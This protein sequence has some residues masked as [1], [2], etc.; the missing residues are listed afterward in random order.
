[1]RLKN[2]TQSG[3]H[4][5]LL[6][7]CTYLL[8]LANIVL[9]EVSITHIEPSSGIPGTRITIF[10][11]GF[12]DTTSNNE[13]LIG[14]TI[15]TV[16]SVKT[17]RLFV[18]VPD[19]SAGPTS[20][21][22]TV[23]STQN[24]SSFGFTIISEPLGQ[25][26]FSSQKVIST[27]GDATVS[28]YSAD[29]DGDGDLDVL[30]ASVG[31]DK[32][33]WYENTDGTGTFGPQQVISIFTNTPWSVYSADLDGDGDMDVLSASYDDNKIAWY[34]N[35]DG[36][37]TFGPQQVITTAAHGALSVYSAD[38]D[39]D[40]DM[41]V[42]SS[43]D[44]INIAWYENTDGAGA[45]GI[46]QVITTLADYA[47]CVYS[48]DLDGDGDMDVL[49]AS[50]GDD[51]IA[52]YE[53]SDG[54][55]TF[56]AQQV[57]TILADR[58]SSVY[59]ADIDGDGNLDVLSAS[60]YNGG[61]KI[62]WYKNID[63]AGTF[64]TQHLITTEAVGAYSVYSGDLD[65]DGDMDVLSASLFDDK[66]AWY[67]NTDGAG[68]FGAQQVIT[69]LADFAY[70]VYSADIDGDGDLDVLS[71]SSYDDK[72]AWYEN[73]TPNV[74]DPISEPQSLH[75][76]IRAGVP[77]LS[78]SPNTEP[79]LAKYYIY[80]DTESQAGAL[81]DSISI[82]D[83]SY[84]DRSAALNQQNFYRIKAVSSIGM[85][86]DYS[87][88][89]S[90]IPPLS[91][92]SIQPNSGIA[93]LPIIL[94]GVGFSENII[95]N[96]LRFG[97]VIAPIDSIKDSRIFTT[98]PIREPGVVNVV[99]EV[100]G[101]LAVW[102]E[103][104]TV[105]PVNRD[106]VIVG[107]QQVID[108]LEYP[109]SVHSA[110]LDGDGDMDIL[111][112]SKDDDKILWFENTDGTGTFGP[113]QEIISSVDGPQCVYS[114]DLDN[115]GDADVIVASV[116]DDKV[117]WY[118]NTDGEGAFGP[119][120]VI[121]NIADGAFSV[122]SADIDGDGDMDVLSASVYDDK[123]AW[124]ENTDGVGGFGS[125]Q[126]I[127]TLAD[128][129]Y[130]V[131][132]GDLD[133][134]G[135][136]DVLSASRENDRIAWYENTDGQ[137]TFG[138]QQVISN[139]AD[140]ARSVFSLDLDGDGDLD[141]LSGS[142]Y[143][144]KI[145]W[146]ENIDGVGTFGPEQVITT[147]LDQ[148]YSI[149]PI[150]FDGDG[151]MDVLSTAN[152][153]DKILWYENTD[154]SGTFGPPQEIT[155]STDGPQAIY[156]ADLDNDGDMDVLST[157]YNDN[158]LAWYENMTPP[159]YPPLAPIN[160]SVSHGD[161]SAE[162]S[163]TLS[164][165]ENQDSLFLY[166]G[167][168]T[169]PNNLIMQLSVS[170]DTFYTD[171]GLQNGLTYYYAVSVVDSLGQESP[172]STVISTIPNRAPVMSMATNLTWNEDNSFQIALDTVLNDD[173]D[174][175]EDIELSIMSN[176][177]SFNLIRDTFTQIIT[178]TPN[179]NY[180]GTEMLII[181]AS[182][183][184][185]DIVIDSTEITI[186][187]VN[188]AP[189]ISSDT[190]V[191]GLEEEWFVYTSPVFDVENDPINFNYVD[192]PDWLEADA[193][194][195]FGIPDGINIDTTVALIV[196]DSALQDTQKVHISI[197]YINDT[198]IQTEPFEPVSISAPTDWNLVLE[199]LQLNFLDEEDGQNLQ[200]SAWSLHPDLDSLRLE[201]T[202]SD[203]NLELHLTD[204]LFRGYGDIMLQ[205]SDAQGE[206]VTDTFRVM[207][208]YD[209]GQPI[210]ILF[211][212]TSIFED[213]SL[214]ILI[215]AVDF[216]DDELLFSASSSAPEVGT[217]IQG[218]ELVISPDDDWWGNSHVTVQVSDGNQIDS[219]TFSLTILP[220]NDAPVIFSIPDT[221]FDEDDITSIRLTY[222]D[223]DD[224]GL[225][226]AAASNTTNLT[227]SINDTVLI[228]TPLANWAGTAEIIWSTADSEFTILDTFMVTVVQINDQP[229]LS[230]NWEGTEIF[231]KDTLGIEYSDADLETLE[232]KGR[233][234]TDSGIS[235]QEMLFNLVELPDD[236]NFIQVV[237]N[238][239][240]TTDAVRTWGFWEVVVCSVWVEDAAT[241]S[242]V[243]IFSKSM[244][245][246]PGD[247]NETGNIDAGDI[248]LLA[249]NYY[250]SGDNIS[251]YD[252]GPS[253]GTAPFLTTSVDS[254][255]NYEDLATFAQMWHYN[256]QNEM[257]LFKTDSL[258]VAKRSVSSNPDWEY[259]YITGFDMDDQSLA[260]GLTPNFDISAYQGVDLEIQYDPIIWPELSAKSTMSSSIDSNLVFIA[261]RQDLGLIRLSMFSVNGV[262]KNNNVV[263]QLE[264]PGRL[265]ISELDEQFVTHQTNLFETYQ[266]SSSFR[267][268]VGMNQDSFIPTDFILHSNYPNPFNV[269]TTIK[270]EIPR[271]TELNISIFDIRGRF[272]REMHSG[273]QQAG[274]HAI[275]WNGLNDRDQG[276]ASG[277]YF[278]L[279]QTPEFRVARKALIL[280]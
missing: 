135:D 146:Y 195:M 24:D 243:G 189:V 276:V 85:T 76:Q 114:S 104:F 161:Q 151:D 97:D 132:T 121:S 92:T 273:P 13:V 154:G 65:G 5:T 217:D 173:S 32:I 241:Q 233:Y 118:E 25:I 162:I 103:L 141:V 223:A 247:F 255:I 246:F 198:P 108:I 126:I 251:H 159:S 101:E 51:K 177:T 238:P 81:I 35:T 183:P 84:M 169:L 186:L 117:T 228:L 242:S 54:A 168:T 53:N 61:S 144:D 155:S 140:G 258:L 10:G 163:W 235:S 66:I 214:T 112:T 199:S 134:D 206:T 201:T 57:I 49:S 129:A 260:L 202:G 145:A 17:N 136:L 181:Q 90:I 274:Y 19:I 234:S 127:T 277:L 115:D 271:D 42:L 83:S 262:L 222:W 275:Q 142:L 212:D 178:L 50:S 204:T 16:D 59:S 60:S 37:G 192:L 267:G 113:Q 196:D 29:L 72:I 240:W 102:S 68:N 210:L 12:S 43:G 164:T 250:D 171:T 143:D 187:S 41:D 184:I 116:Y 133:N 124:Y 279:L 266:L 107:P 75:V 218:S 74:H 193:D 268:I 98:V 31:D 166:R 73:L 221:S 39:G 38:L 259:N 213:E 111:A 272:V 231:G 4:R 257:S 62:A 46:Q 109:S 170:A 209:P 18:N 6:A 94:Y 131:F 215:E 7:R 3:F 93:G 33:A 100:S 26:D 28:V 2:L 229:E 147:L 95:E 226:F 11:I 55:G 203:V 208:G 270:Y 23:Y 139:T 36:I 148:V 157:S 230:I 188:D 152:G 15:T 47:I 269:S 261:H 128:I 280:K 263:L 175:V 44:N 252:I 278:I 176:P 106:T 99:L 30:S 182:D 1:M 225:F 254:I 200:F 14:G 27:S 265:E 232:L 86:S 190:S 87:E 256:A 219:V 110:D 138:S 216:E 156:T 174:L 8:F 56:G 70:S 58:A 52:W 153:D 77:M 207:I 211:P 158:K 48:A 167:L 40:G 21:E 88:E 172:L 224:D 45:F 253:I 22:V 119:Q 197:Y 9:G 180:Y 91:I 137:G 236:Q 239:I 244:I 69:I 245:N 125:P 249:T 264:I 105:I 79:H 237:W 80:R 123:I 150:D 71:A 149:H 78:W 63:G 89:V 122:Y 96:T 205:A 160:L 120:Q 67:E 34:E 191:I 194:S 185:G 220:I 64:G 165:D 130:S 179:E 248:G 20:V 227:T 82:P